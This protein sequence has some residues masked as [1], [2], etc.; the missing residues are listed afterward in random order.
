MKKKLTLTID[1][2]VKERAKL[3]AKKRGLSVSQMVEDYLRIVSAETEKWRPREGT[4]VSRISGSVKA[5]DTLQSYSDIVSESLIK[6]HE[7]G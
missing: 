7:D 3:A 2:A 4:V 1:Q 5:G 6:K